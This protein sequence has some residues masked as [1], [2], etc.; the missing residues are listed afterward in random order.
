V[1]ERV[2]A[3]LEFLPKRDRKRAEREG[4]EAAR[5]SQRRARTGA[6]DSALTLCGLWFRDVACV[7]D[8][9]EDLLHATDR[10][11]ALREDA[12]GRE[13]SH[14]LRDAVGL[15]DETRAALILNPT[16]ELALEALA[17]RLGR[18]LG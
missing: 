1:Q 8:G 13:T 17:S 14:R 10:L 15:V 12:A 4:L 9:V 6:I 2:T 18:L 5:R 16:E 11:D 3:E 7:V